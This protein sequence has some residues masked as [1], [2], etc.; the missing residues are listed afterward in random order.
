MKNFTTLFIITLFSLA[1]FS[2]INDDHLK[3]GEEAPIITGVDQFDNTI[4]SKDILKEKKMLVVFY[5]GNWCPY[6]RKHLASLQENLE[7]L[8]KKGLFVVVVTPEKV[9]KINETTKKLAATFSIL[10]DKDNSIM[11]SYKVAFTVNEENVTSYFG[12]TQRKISEYNAA[13]NNTLPVPATYL[14]DQ[15]GKIVYVHYD[16]DHHE[17][18]DFK[19]IIKNL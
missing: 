3:V 8:S 13:N 16:P 2:Q 12:F 5:R 6:C 7:E 17:R 14:I 11:K 19:E 4:N 18:S 15:D 1:S 10:H 9:E